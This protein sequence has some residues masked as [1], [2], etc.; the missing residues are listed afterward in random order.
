MAWSKLPT[1]SALKA[2][3][4]YEFPNKTIRDLFMC[5]EVRP[6]VVEVVPDADEFVY[7]ARSGKA[8]LCRFAL[9]LVVAGQAPSYLEIDPGTSAAARVAAEHKKRR[10]AELGATIEFTTRSSMLLGGLRLRNAL[11]MH[12]YLS[13]GIEMDT[14][15][16]ELKVLAAIQSGTQTVIDIATSAALP[17]NEALIAAI[18]LYKR[19]AVMPASDTTLVGL[20]WALRACDEV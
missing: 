11:L 9:K 17:P 6:G 15:M 16:A 10:A 20:R 19:E 13:R 5:S 7:L 14:A 4:T 2:G 18:R 1:E 12:G 8:V 3:R